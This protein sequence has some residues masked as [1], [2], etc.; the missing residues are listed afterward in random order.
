MTPPRP[1]LPQKT[2][3]ITRRTVDR[4]FLLGPSEEVNQFFQYCLAY[5]APN[6]DIEIHAFCFLSNHYHIVLTDTLGK[7]PDFMEWL[8]GVV[9][10]RLNAYYG[11]YGCV[12]DSDD[13]SMVELL[14]PQAVLEK[15]VYTL[16]NP[17]AAGLVSQGHEWPGLRSSTLSDGPQRIVA[18]KPG[19]FFREDGPL[20]DEV[21]LLVG[22]PRS[23]AEL[24]DAPRGQDVHDAVFGREAEIREER[25]AAGR[26]FLGR[27]AVLQQH[28]ESRPVSEKPRDG[29]KPKVACR[30]KLKRVAWLQA[31]KLFLMGYREAYRQFAAGVRDV[32]FPAGTYWMR[33][34]LGVACHDP[35]LG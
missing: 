32:V 5:A 23:Y 27:K 6:F 31:L 13:Y 15:M 16:V 14:D 19:F 9:A 12:F 25:K 26:G 33:V 11:R 17:V 22:L 35:P 3:L 18:K 20:P 10:R 28:H 2:Y 1:I 30:D 8:N 24:D 29:V 7:L 21:E 4:K 34:H